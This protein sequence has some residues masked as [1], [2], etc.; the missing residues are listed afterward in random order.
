VVEETLAAGLEVTRARKLQL[1]LIDAEKLYDAHKGRFFYE[2]L[3]RHITSGPVVAL[4]LQTVDSTGDAVERWRRLLGATKVYKTAYESPTS[5]R[6]S[7]GLT[8]TRNVGHGSDSSQSVSIE[9]A[10]F[11]ESV[12]ATDIS[13]PSKN[14][15][16]QL[17]VGDLRENAL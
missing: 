2:R 10:L 1:S 7:F 17:I 13:R 6:G 14:D 8:D 12:T 3:I 5:L 9:S 16:L 11:F 15:L 4:E